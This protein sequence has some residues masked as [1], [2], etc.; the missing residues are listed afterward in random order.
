MS[1]FVIYFLYI[2]IMAFKII[3]NDITKVKA[4]VIVNSAN[5][6]PICAGYRTD[7]AIYEAAGYN[8]LLAA[9]QQIG[10]IEVGMAAVTPAF[11]LPAKYIVH[12][13]GPIWI[14]GCFGE[15]DKL[16]SCYRESLLKAVELKAK[17]IAFPLISTGA[18][19]FP[20]N[21]A[22]KI[23]MDVFK[24]F[25]S[26]RKLEII[27]VV[28]DNESFE[29]SHGW[30]DFVES[31]IDKHYVEN[32]IEE[33]L[34]MW[35][36]LTE[37]TPKHKDDES[38]QKH[39]NADEVVPKHR[40]YDDFAVCYYS[41]SPRRRFDDDEPRRQ[42]DESCALQDE[43][44]VCAA[45]QSLAP[46]L[47]SER[48]SDFHMQNFEQELHEK[49]KGFANFTFGKRLA[50]YLYEKNLEAAQVYNSVFMDRKHF[51][52]LLS[53]KVKQPKRETILALAIGLKLNVY[54]TKDLLSYAGYSFTPYNMTDVIVSA[55]IERNI[56]DV[57]RINLV[58]SS[59]NLPQLG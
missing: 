51:S 33:R 43:E 45:K 16:R 52:K 23:A 4:D 15:A 57:W 8:D 47:E 9:R 26:N 18:L 6:Q 37:P 46:M 54:E 38:A 58:L 35:E 55:F 36:G 5:L 12:T 24:E 44:P 25:T 2:K 49:L 27:L 17:S 20:K 50:Y 40:N 11:K 28:Y 39:G 42:A 10:V 34:T 30:I 22:M 21:Y 7:A 32:Q 3:R 48:I 41:C 19:K 14:N 13:V 29:L 59:K 56:Y 53:D 1:Y 31:Y